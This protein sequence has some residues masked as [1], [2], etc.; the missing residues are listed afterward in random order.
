MKGGDATGKGHYISSYPANAI[1]KNTVI[2]YARASIQP[3]YFRSF[4]EVMAGSIF[5]FQ[6]RYDESTTC[7]D[8]LGG[9]G[10][11]CGLGAAD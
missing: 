11:D 8:R 9:G 7:F 2:P 4:R 1:S 3:Q 10:G 6:G 5:A